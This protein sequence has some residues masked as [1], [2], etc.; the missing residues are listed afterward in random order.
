[1]SPSRYLVHVCIEYLTQDH[2][3]TQKTEL[4]NIDQND[5]N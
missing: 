1:M 2:E 5:Q 4:G 3:E